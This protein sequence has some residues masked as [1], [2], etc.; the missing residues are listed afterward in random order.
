M[1]ESASHGKVDHFLY[2][3]LNRNFPWLRQKTQELQ[4]GPASEVDKALRST[5]MMSKKK[6]TNNNRRIFMK[7]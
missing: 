7:H 4:L 3:Q 2:K 1:A 5:F 6:S